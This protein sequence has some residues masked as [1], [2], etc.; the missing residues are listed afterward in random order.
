MKFDLY[1]NVIDI[2][3]ALQSQQVQLD[4]AVNVLVLRLAIKE[5]AKYVHIR[6]NY[7]TSVPYFTNIWNIM[8]VAVR[9]LDP[10]AAPRRPC[11]CVSNPAWRRRVP[12]APALADARAQRHR[13]AA[14]DK[15]HA[16][17]IRLDHPSGLFGRREP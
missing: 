2:E 17:H 14:G 15:H 13:A 3:T 7:G 9:A 10:M 4:I 16:V 8:E 1:E 11:L 5:F 6:Y 12:V